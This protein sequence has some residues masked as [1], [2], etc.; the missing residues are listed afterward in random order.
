MSI[1]LFPETSSE[2]LPILW[3]QQVHPLLGELFAQK[4]IVDSHRPPTQDDIETWIAK[5]DDPHVLKQLAR[6]EEMEGEIA[7]IKLRLSELATEALHSPANDDER[8]AARSKFNQLKNRLTA[9]LHSLAHIA[10]E[11]SEPQVVEWVESALTQIPKLNT[12]SNNHDLKRMREWLQENHPEANIKSRGTIPLRWK[13][14][15]YNRSG[16]TGND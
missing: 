4:N 6:I 5:S 3:R 14:V 12:T 10:A 15:Y 11:E 16:P 13:Q 2:L 7:T 9:S 1:W 8:K